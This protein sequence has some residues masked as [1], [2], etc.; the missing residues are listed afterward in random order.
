MAFLSRYE[1]QLYGV[2]G[3]R[4]SG[5]G[6]V[7]VDARGAAF[8]STLPTELS[9]LKTMALQVGP[10]PLFMTASYGNSWDP[11]WARFQ[12]VYDAGIAVLAEGEARTTFISTMRDIRNAA[13]RIKNDDGASYWGAFQAILTGNPLQTLRFVVG[14]NPA[15]VARDLG[16][17]ARSEYGGALDWLKWL[18]GWAWDHKWWLAGGVAALAV[19][20]Q[21]VSLGLGLRRMT[22]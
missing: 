10:P 20:P 12:G 16:A 15:D 8:L 7:T 11:W 3:V 21:A 1:L 6:D 2:S 5:L 13:M 19:A 22:K 18:S 17:A 9:V 14:S 4:A